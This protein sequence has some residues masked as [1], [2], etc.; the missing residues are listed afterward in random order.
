MYRVCALGTCVLACVE[1]RGAGIFVNHSPSSFETRFLIKPRAHQL[2][3]AGDSL[4]S[5]VTDAVTT[6]S[7]Y[8][9]ADDDPS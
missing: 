1:A 7:L 8:M 5:G 9:H 4:H 6:P 2:G 3:W